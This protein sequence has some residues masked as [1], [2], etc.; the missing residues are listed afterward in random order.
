[1]VKKGKK[2]KMID[3]DDDDEDEDDDE[4]DDDEPDLA[5][6]RFYVVLFNLKNCKFQCLFNVFSWL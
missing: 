1:M 4:E 2:L 3:S 5:D 6:V